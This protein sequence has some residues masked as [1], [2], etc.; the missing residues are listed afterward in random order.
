MTTRMQHYV[1][2]KYLEAWQQDS[3]QIYCSREGKVFKSNPV[4]VMKMRDY[5]RLSRITRTDMAFL[6]AMFIK[7][8][9]ELRKLHRSFVESLGKIAN[10]NHAIQESGKA[11]EEERKYLNDLVIETEE[12][13]QSEIEQQALPIL[14]QLRHKQTYF[15]SDYYSAMGFFQFISHQYLR[16]RASRERIGEELRDSPFGRD[17]GHLKHILCHCVAD[18]IGSSLFVDRIKFEIIFLQCE[19]NIE[20][21][22]GDQ[23]IVNLFRAHGEDSPPT[24]MALY[25]PLEP[26]LSMILLPKVCGLSS[27][28]VPPIIVDELNNLIAQETKEFLV[29]KQ[30]E[31]LQRTNKG[32]HGGRQEDGHIL[33]ERLKKLLRM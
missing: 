12:K 2:R 28:N 11:T 1:W 29:A 14:E 9:P 6:D 26:H 27:M 16:T 19:S 10:A 31:S 18:N 23:P 22:T 20:F 8:N 25:Y 7:T 32:L 33:I 17:F 30:M 13:L 3:R 24:E 4:N 21:I 5:Y 15:L